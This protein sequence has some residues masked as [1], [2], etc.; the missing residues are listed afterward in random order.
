MNDS[1]Q[2]RRTP[3]ANDPVGSLVGEFMD[4]KQRE[5]K[6]EAVRTARP[7]RSPF[8]IPA[9]VALCLAIWVAPSLMPPREPVLRVREFHSSHKRLPV[10]LVEA[11]VDTSGVIYWRGTDSAAF[12]L[13]TSVQG[14]RMV[15]RST[16]P[17]SVFLGPNLRIRGVG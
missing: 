10:N 11:G 8:A 12:E 5:L 13:S 1:Q 17:D 6:A 15:Y 3:L 4:E 7:R 14:T 16:Q 9:L 2:S